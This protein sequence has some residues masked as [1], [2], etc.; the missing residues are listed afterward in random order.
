MTRAE[1]SRLSSN[2]S[3]LRRRNLNRISLAMT[4][5]NDEDLSN[6]DFVDKYPNNSRQETENNNHIFRRFS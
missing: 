5:Q 3:R 2:I 6:I 1:E 4:A